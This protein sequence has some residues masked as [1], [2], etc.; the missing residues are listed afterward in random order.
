MKLSMAI[1]LLILGGCSPLQLA[2]SSGPD[3]VGR[4]WKYG[5]LPGVPL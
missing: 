2:Y 1:L 5:F 4:G 3:G